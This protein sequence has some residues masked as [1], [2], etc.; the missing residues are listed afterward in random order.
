LLLLKKV[1]QLYQG[2]ELNIK[3]VKGKL[4][5]TDYLLEGE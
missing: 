5:V 2:W 4:A 3:R 1:I